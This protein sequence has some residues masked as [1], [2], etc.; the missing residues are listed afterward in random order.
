MKKPAVSAIAAA[1][2]AV[3]ALGGTGV[4]AVSGRQEQNGGPQPLAAPAAPAAE[5][6]GEKDETVYILTGADGAV[7]RI[8]VSDWLKNPAGSGQI[9][10]VSSLTGVENVKGESGWTE[11]EGGVRLWDAQGEDVYYQGGVEKD[12]PVD[13]AVT[14]TL[15]GRAISAADL[16]GKSGRVTIR[17]DY[18]N[19][20]YEMVEVNGTMTKICVPFAMV[21]GVL[22]DNSIFRNVEVTN[23]RLYNDGDRTVV[24]GGALPGLQENLNLDS[25]D[26]ELPAYVEIT[27][28]VE[29]FSLGSTFTVA[30]SGLFRDL[31][32]SG[33]ED[34]G[35]LEGSLDQ[36]TDAMDQLMDGSSQLHRGLVTLLERCDALAA[37]VD[38][39]TE[40]AA[41]LKEGSGSLY[42]GAEA[43]QEGA[44]S[45]Q[46]GAGQ[47][48]EGTAA[49]SDG[50]DALSESSAALN[51][52]ALQV[53]EAMLSSA[54]AQ[55]AAAGLELPA[56]TPENYAQVLD[57]AIAAM[58]PEAAESAAA[59]KA[60]LDSYSGFCQGLRSY[61]AGVDEAAGGA[62]DLRSGAD[63]LASGAQELRAGAAEL[64]TGAASLQAGAGQ[65]YEG[66]LTLQGS[67]PALTAGVAQLRDGALAL[68]DGLERFN[69]EG[70]QKLADALDGELEDLLSRLRA[71]ADAAAGYQSFSGISDG[72]QGQVKFIYRTDAVGE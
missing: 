66:V 38:S 60:S 24:V 50:L 15:D 44:D 10:D 56:L 1:L 49:L 3:L 9:S 64:E 37:G 52:G 47:L 58:P 7:E 5:P 40:G 53:F 41:A 39:L 20:Q 62:A 36:M 29:G 65:L 34:L 54:S 61:T 2:A 70:V 59:L 69:E 63:R 27:A 13:L 25:A 23:G 17:F 26:L 32:G 55:L 51:A 16:A 18:V 14:Y 45:L 19:R 31:D 28:D 11:G 72:T 4:C 8:I 68:S 6:A 21:T 43:L 12:L 30:I 57:S 35:G 48:R 71:T 22:L 46:T 42:G 67:M 33:P